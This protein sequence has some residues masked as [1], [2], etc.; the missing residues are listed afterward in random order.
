MKEQQWS[1]VEERIGGEVGKRIVKELRDLYSLCDR[2]MLEWEA[3][4]YDDT[5]GGFYYATSAVNAEGYLP[6]IE[7]TW[8]AIMLPYS[9]GALRG[10]GTDLESTL[11]AA[12]PEWFRTKVRDYFISLQDKDGQFYHPQWEKEKHTMSRLGRDRGSAL[13]LIRAFG[14][15]PKYELTSPLSEQAK[16]LVPERFRSVDNFRAFLAEQDITHRSYPAIS[17]ILTQI[18]QIRAHGSAMGEDLMAIVMDWLVDNIREDNGLWENTVRIGSVNGMHK[19]TRI[20]N[21]EK[22]CIPYAAAAVESTLQVIFSDEE[23]RAVVDVY[24][25]WHVLSDILTNMCNYGDEQTKAQGMAL[26]KRIIESAPEGIRASREQ[27]SKFHHS[28]GAFSYLLSGPCPTNQGMPSAV[29]GYAE[30]DANGN[31]CALALFISIFGALGISDILVP[32]FDKDDFEY[33]VS[34]LEARRTSK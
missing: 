10:Y 28:D 32:I 13:T 30:G 23:R 21:S 34:L 20:F 25:P 7:S 29:P 24:N 2:R 5:V 6:D 26:R 27:V 4:L 3:S 17:L 19:A 31:G 1:A 18:P 14:G 9:C 33:Y 8:D 15:K 16:E 11:S 22:R 12:Y